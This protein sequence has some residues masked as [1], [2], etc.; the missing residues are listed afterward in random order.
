MSLYTTTLAAL[1]AL[2]REPDGM[3]NGPLV[4]DVLTSAARKFLTAFQSGAPGN[5]AVELTFV[6]PVDMTF[7][8]GLADS[9][10]EAGTGAT[11]EAVF[12][13]ATDGGAAWGT[14][15]FAIAGTTGVFAAA[16]DEEVSAGSIVTITA[17]ASAD[18]TLADIAF[19]LVGMA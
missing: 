17:P 8:A 4:S 19:T 18:A 1:N 15:T 16:A 10:A 2:F 12:E 11:A 5:S 14:I 13:I 3:V 7:K 9:A 6:A